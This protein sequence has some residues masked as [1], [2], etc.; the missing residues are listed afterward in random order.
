[1]QAASKKTGSV[2]Y[3]KPLRVELND[4]FGVLKDVSPDQVYS[5]RKGMDE[6]TNSTHDE[7]TNVK[8]ASTSKANDGQQEQTKKK[9]QEK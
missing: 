7:P 6:A 2:F 5:N 3:F 4:C 1:M 9:Q 8:Q